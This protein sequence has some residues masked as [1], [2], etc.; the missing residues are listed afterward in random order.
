V[1]V[2]VDDVG[3]VVVVAYVYNIGLAGCVV[4]DGIVAV[5]VV[6]V[7]GAD[8]VDADVLLLV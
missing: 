3:V 8:A 4:C 2:V 1:R 7:V 6:E 5:A